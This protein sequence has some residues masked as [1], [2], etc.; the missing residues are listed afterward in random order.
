MLGAPVTVEIEDDGVYVLVCSQ[1]HRSFHILSNPKFEVLFEMGLLAFDDGYTREAVATMAASVEEFFRFFVKCI[2]AKRKLYENDRFYE[3]QKFWKLI[4]RA[5]PQLGAFAAFYFLEFE[6]CPAYPDRKSTEFRNSVIHRGQI[7]KSS[8]VMEYGDKLVK[9]MIPVYRE[10]RKGFEAL[11]ARGI[12]VM[13]KFTKRTEE[14][15]L[16]S[17]YPTAVSY[18]ALREEEPR[19]TD[20]LEYVRKNK[21]RFFTA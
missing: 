11:I 17:N 13:T 15:P 7:P 21:G 1:G 8:E 4:A 18:L 6:K 14:S 20:A 5:E 16:S 9:F 2:F 19:F 3:A 10:Y 12:E